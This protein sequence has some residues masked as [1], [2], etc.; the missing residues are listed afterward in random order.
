MVA[1]SSALTFVL[2]ITRAVAVLSECRVAHRSQRMFCSSFESTVL[3]ASRAPYHSCVVVWVLCPVLC[4]SFVAVHIMTMISAWRWRISSQ[5]RLRLANSRQE[6]SR[7]L[8]LCCRFPALCASCVPVRIMTMVSS[9]RWHISI[10]L[11]RGLLTADRSAAAVY[12]Q[13]WTLCCDHSGC[14]NLQPQWALQN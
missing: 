7:A 6:C 14:Q 10:Q 11:V 5:L 8:W 13:I 3:G 4:A 1:Y 12:V 9:G 2:V